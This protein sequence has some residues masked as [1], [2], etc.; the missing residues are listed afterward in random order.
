MEKI[1]VLNHKQINGALECIEKG[2]D[3]KIYL[4]AAKNKSIACIGGI[5]TKYDGEKQLVWIRDQGW[6]EI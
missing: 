3:F 4:D 6:V 1:K 5:L 2:I